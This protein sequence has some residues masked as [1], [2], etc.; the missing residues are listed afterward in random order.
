M[1]HLLGLADRVRAEQRRTGN[2]IQPRLK[3]SVSAQERWLW[4]MG[5]RPGGSDAHVSPHPSLVGCSLALPAEYRA[6][7]VPGTGPTRPSRFCEL[8]SCRHAGDA[9]A[10]CRAAALILV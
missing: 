9:P 1:N 3:R 8:L 7:T 4:G 2:G 10:W 5:N 6:R